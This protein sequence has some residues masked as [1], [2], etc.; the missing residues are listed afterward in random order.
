MT[1]DPDRMMTVTLPSGIWDHLCDRLGDYADQTEERGMLGDCIACDRADPGMCPK[2][3]REAEYGAQVRRW[4]DQIV[5]QLGAASSTLTELVTRTGLPEDTD[6]RHAAHD[7]KGRAL[8]A[9]RRHGVYTLGDLARCQ[10]SDLL[11]LRNFGAGS[12]ATLKTYLYW[13]AKK[14]FDTTTVDG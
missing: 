6:I 13:L 9:M 12:L 8:N 10:E 2:H 11:D 4:R 3:Q 1:T 5:D 14:H 7:L